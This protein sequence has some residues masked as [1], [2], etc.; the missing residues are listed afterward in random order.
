MSGILGSVAGG[1]TGGQSSGQTGT[2]NSGL[3]DFPD[4]L[5][6][7][8]TPIGASITGEPGSGSSGGD[9]TFS[10]YSPDIDS[11]TAGGDSGDVNCDPTGVCY[12]GKKTFLEMELK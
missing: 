9:A 11:G 3:I 8:G 5:P 6:G 1:L 12:D 10:T 7:G 2:D 4:T